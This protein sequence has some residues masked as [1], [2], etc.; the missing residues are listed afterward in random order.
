MLVTVLIVTAVGLL[1]GAGALLLFR[2]Q[3]QLR[4][5]RQHELEKVYA[6]RSALN[7]IKNDTGE[8]SEAGKPFR[9]HTGS[10]RNLGV[11][12]KPVAAVFP[13]TNNASHFDMRKGHFRILPGQ[14]DPGLDYEYGAAGVTNQ[15]ALTDLQIGNRDTSGKWGVAFR[16]VSEAG[17]ATW[18]VN[19]GMYGTGGWLQENYGRR[20]CFTPLDYVGGDADTTADIMRL[21]IIRSVT[22]MEN[23]VGCRHGWPL[24]QAGERAL[25]FQIHPMPGGRNKNNAVMTLSEYWYTGLAT[26]ITT[27]L[28]LSNCPSLCPMGL[29][30]ASDKVSMFYIENASQNTVPASARGYTF[31]ASK[32]LTRETYE[33][34]AQSQ[35]IG[36]KTYPGIVTNGFGKVEAPE[37]RAVFEVEA[38][39]SKRTG[40]KIADIDFLTDF[41]VTP[42][43]QYDVFLEHP[44]AVTNL[45]TVAQKVG[46]YARGAQN[47]ITMLTYDTH[48]TE[49]KGFRRDEREQARKNGR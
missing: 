26:N 36:G 27:L 35:T 49:H 34:F 32:Q 31:S 13:N 16:D 17:G 6:V 33:Y 18:W 24:S 48:G 15:S 23:R 21:C 47:S 22:N 14:Y 4:I 8:I 45:A 43:Y 28:C 30:V 7:F 12:V 42:A 5:D 41:K 9:Y 39:S 19:I 38:V 37:L 25:V 10:G 1:F 40:G 44:V 46:T 3:C 2:F 29:Q 11:I 20:Y